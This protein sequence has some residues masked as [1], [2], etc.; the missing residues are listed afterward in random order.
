MPDQISKNMTTAGWVLISI[1]GIVAVAG[2]GYVIIMLLASPIPVWI[3]LLAV[4]GIVG[5]AL[6]MASVIRDRFKD[7]KDDKYKDIEV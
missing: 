4:V 3:K 1:I 5:F 7:R 2:G 6:L